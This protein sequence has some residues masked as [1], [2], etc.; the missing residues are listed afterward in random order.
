MRRGCRV[1]SGSSCRVLSARA[2]VTSWRCAGPASSAPAPGRGAS[3]PSVQ[4]AVRVL[5]PRCVVV[6]GVCSSAFVKGFGTVIQPMQI[7]VLGPEGLGRSALEETLTRLGYVVMAAEARPDGQAPASG[8]IVMLDMRG[9]DADWA[10][11]AEGLVGDDRPVMI[12]SERPRRLMRALSG[13][14]AGTMVMTGSES[15]AGY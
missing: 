2:M 9:E 5:H 13:R 7:L 6:G 12:V 3:A 14:A 15:D 8:D 10:G 4:R 11:L 1:R